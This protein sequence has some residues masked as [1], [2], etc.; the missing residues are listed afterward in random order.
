MGKLKPLSYPK[1]IDQVI[2]VLKVVVVAVLELVE[3]L[4]FV[5]YSISFVKFQ[6]VKAV[7]WQLMH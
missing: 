1:P 6:N 3:S 2:L 5:E 7:H 4:V